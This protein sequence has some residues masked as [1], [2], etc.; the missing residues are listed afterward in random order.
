[1]SGK[2]FGGFALTQLLG[3]L[4][5]LSERMWVILVVTGLCWFIAKRKLVANRKAHRALERE[6]N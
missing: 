2:G 1:L 4:F 5:G 3:L 6:V